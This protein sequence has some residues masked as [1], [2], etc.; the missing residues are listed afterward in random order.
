MALYWPLSYGDTYGKPAMQQLLMR[1]DQKFNFD[2]WTLLDFPCRENLTIAGLFLQR[3]GRQLTQ[4]QRDFVSVLQDSAI[5]PYEIRSVYPGQGLEVTDLRSNARLR[6][7]ERSAT[8]TLVQWDI[9]CTRLV[10]CPDGHHEMH[11]GLFQF[12]SRFKA[13]LMENIKKEHRKFQK[14]APG[15]TEDRFMK[16]IAYRFNHWWV[17]M[18]YFQPLPQLQTTDGE[19]LTLCRALFEI[20][21]RKT[22]EAAL[23]GV[24]HLHRS[25]HDEYVWEK[26]DGE[27]ILG[28]IRLTG[29]E[30]VLETISREREMRGRKMLEE[31]AGPAL[32]YRNTETASG[33]ELLARVREAGPPKEEP[34]SPELQEQMDAGV[35]AY[36]DGHYRSWLDQPI[37]ALG[38]RTPRHA[39]TLKTWRPKL[40]DL[41]KEMANMEARS[42]KPYNLS[43][44]WTK[45][46]LAEDK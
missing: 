13:E 4:G 39:A 16:E 40:I 46:R 35:K 11:G 38:G 30:L 41:L 29:N 15:E 5:R 10:P 7:Q 8:A 27:K 33:Q 21:D 12:P 34:V 31:A 14:K 18:V 1:E 43:W 19:E 36:L 3:H 22:L 37:P 2:F 45:L 25:E 23:V 9:L 6:V 17:E 20:A 42:R 32:R 44:L 24:S 26:S 28:H